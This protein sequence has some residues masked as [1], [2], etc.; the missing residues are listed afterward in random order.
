MM[1]YRYA[2]KKPPDRL[3]P[4]KAEKEA[5]KQN[6]QQLQKIPCDSVLMLRAPLILL[7]R[8]VSLRPHLSGPA[9]Q[10]LVV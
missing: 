10:F 2:P 1:S 5:A 9:M 7:V 8:L 4:N 6:R 3:R